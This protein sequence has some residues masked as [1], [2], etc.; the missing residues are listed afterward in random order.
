MNNLTSQLQT[1]ELDNSMLQGERDLAVEE[2]DTAL[3]RSGHL[4]SIRTPSTEQYVV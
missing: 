3:R 4:V 1:V 2:R